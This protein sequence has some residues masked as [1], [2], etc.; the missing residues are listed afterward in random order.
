MSALFI[1]DKP[2][3]LAIGAHPDD[4]ELGCAGFLHRLI[5]ERG[6]KVYFAILTGGELSSTTEQYESARREEEARAAAGFIL[7]CST[8]SKTFSRHISFGKM[9]DG[10]LNKEGHKPIWFIEQ[11]LARHKRA[12]LDIILT[13]S[14]EELH[15]DHS[16]TNRA[17][18]SAARNF[19]GS[20]LFY[21]SPS[22]VPNK[23]S[24]TFFVQLNEKQLRMKNESLR[25][26][27]SQKGKAFLR[28]RTIRDIARSW[29][30]FHR[31]YGANLEAFCVHQ[32]FWRSGK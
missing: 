8:K 32:T 1:P 5:H 25:Y 28:N 9:K 6:A 21:Q 14:P 22:T 13:H 2:N 20:I 12:P 18:L 31:I 24:P 30:V 10:A 26:H 7:G 23:F 15:E 4:I 29:A 16:S 11:E 19:H 27:V 17:T 3:V